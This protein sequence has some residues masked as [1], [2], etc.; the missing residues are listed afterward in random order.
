QILLREIILQLVAELKI[1]EKRDI[2]YESV[3]G[4][5]FRHLVH[6]MWN[7]KS[8]PRVTKLISDIALFKRAVCLLFSLDFVFFYRFL[9]FIYGEEIKNKGCTWI[10]SEKAHLLMETVEE[11]YFT[12]NKAQSGEIDINDSVDIRDKADSGR[13]SNTGVNEELYLKNR[14]NNKRLKIN[15]NKT[16]DLI[17]TFYAK[18]QEL[19]SD[20]E[21]ETASIGDDVEDFSDPEIKEIQGDNVFENPLYKS[22]GL[23]GVCSGSLEEKIIFS[24]SKVRNLIKIVKENS[25]KRILVVT[26]EPRNIEIAKHIFGRHLRYLYHRE[27][28]FKRLNAD[29]AILLEPDL[30]A[31]RILERL[32]IEPYVMFYRNS[33]EEEKYLNEIR[34]EKHTFER[35]IR[36]KAHVSLDFADEC[37]DG[38]E[39]IVDSRELRCTLPYHLYKTAN[40]TVSMLPEGDYVIGDICIERKNIYDFLIS[41][42]C[43]L[44]NQFRM[45]TH[46][47]KNVYLL[48]EFEKRSCIGDYIDKSGATSVYSKFS[49][50]IQH[51]QPKIIWSNSHVHTVSFFKHLKP[52]SYIK[53]KSIDPILQEILLHIPGI[54]LYNIK[55]ILEVFKSLRSLVVATREELM[56]IENGNAIYEFFR[57]KFRDVQ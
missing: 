5:N 47:Y 8:K 46:K 32:S 42:N 27:M 28:R 44:Y 29:L 25:N 9:K 35:L 20:S 12:F 45:A 57:K 54:N 31:L 18:T 37:R 48:L 13:I 2:N 30:A 56:G 17:S 43:R 40:I 24:N 1:E 51:F 15:P 49:L 55:R 36:E 21:D 7:Y 4:G 50:F 6:T 41:L 39:I 53:P 33:L 34:R 26:S 14:D 52:V 3:M 10:N 22:T 11:I 23:A 38:T 16:E 19:N